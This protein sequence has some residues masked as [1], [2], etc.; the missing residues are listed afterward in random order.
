MART[1]VSRTGT[2]LRLL[3][4]SRLQQFRTSYDEPMFR[5]QTVLTELGLDATSRLKTTNTIIEKLRRERTS[6]FGVV[7]MQVSSSAIGTGKAQE[8][9]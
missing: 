1:A 8:A 2:R 6:R 3:A 7:L 5:A 4:L 9:G